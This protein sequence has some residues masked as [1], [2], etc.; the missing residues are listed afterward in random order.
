M[1]YH[2]TFKT[3]PMVSGV[4][5]NILELNNLH[6]KSGGDYYCYGN[7]HDDSHFFLAKATLK[8]YSK[9]ILVAHYC[10]H[11]HGSIMRV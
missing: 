8:V 10:L 1:W 4:M 5:I 11:W 3:E 7:Y 6:S 9:N 2:K